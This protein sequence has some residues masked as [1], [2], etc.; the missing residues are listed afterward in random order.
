ML[1]LRVMVLSLL[2]LTG[3]GSV[4]TDAET[5]EVARDPA[6]GPLAAGAVLPS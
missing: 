1:M 2:V 6:T 3:A 5:A 4:V